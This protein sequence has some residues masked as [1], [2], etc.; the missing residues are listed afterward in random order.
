M[1]ALCRSVRPR[2]LFSALLAQVAETLRPMYA[3]RVRNVSSFWPVADHLVNETLCAAG[4]PLNQSADDLGCAYPK[5][6]PFQITGKPS[7]SV[8][9]DSSQAWCPS[10]RTGTSSYAEGGDEYLR[11]AFDSAR[12]YVENGYTEFIE[13]T[14]A[15]AVYAT[16]IEIGEPSGMGSIVRIK[17]LDAVTGRWYTMWE[18]PDGEGDPRVQYRGRLRAEYRIFRPLPICATTFKTDTIRL[19]LDTRTVTDWNELDYVQLTGAAVLPAGVLPDGTRVVLYVPEPDAFGDDAFTYTLSDCPF[20]PNRQPLPATV[21]VSIRA[22][23]DMPHAT[24]HTLTDLGECRVATHG[25]LT[26]ATIDLTR[27]VT[28]ADGDDLTYTVDVVRGEV[29]A[30]IAHGGVLH[31]EWPDG[32]QPGFEVGYSAMDPLGGHA[33]AQILYHPQCSAGTPA[34]RTVALA[35][36]FGPAR[37]D[38]AQLGS[39]RLGPARPGIG[40]AM[41]RSF[42][43]AGRVFDRSLIECVPCAP[44]FYAQPLASECAACKPGTRRPFLRRKQTIRPVAW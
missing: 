42:A 6:H 27:F 8:Y 13:V 33:S 31:I 35:L 21:A 1:T 36:A 2:R 30:R 28:D 44:G 22:V 12:S 9:G 24:N 40:R 17:A 15:T 19:E 5:W 38:P 32:Q 34:H 11:F 23:N 18:A 7:T 20:D 37:P 25:P 14:F 43:F 3:A 29:S 39:T 10:T 4:M 16:S 41:K 26:V